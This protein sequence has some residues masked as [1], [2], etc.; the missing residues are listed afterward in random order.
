MIDT[1][2]LID[3]GMNFVHLI[4]EFFQCF[5]IFVCVASKTE[6]YKLLNLNSHLLH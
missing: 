4:F 1:Y 2:S 5:S 3:Y 6:N